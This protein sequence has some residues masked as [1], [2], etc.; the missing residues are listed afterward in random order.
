MYEHAGVVN[1]PAAKQGSLLN[2]SPARAG[3]AR[4]GCTAVGG[5]HGFKKPQ[6]RTDSSEAAGIEPG[7][8]PSPTAGAHA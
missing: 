5:F 8:T 7:H 4:I 2:R 1:L 6:E 3:E